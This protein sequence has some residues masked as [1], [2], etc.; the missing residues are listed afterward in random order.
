MI[1]KAYMIKTLVAYI[2]SVLTA[3]LLAALFATQSV[4]ASLIGMGISV[5]WMQRL[6]MSLHDMVGM[7]GI[8]LPLVTVG[9]LIALGVAGVL[10]RRNPTKRTV[11]FILAGAVAMIA[12]HMALKWAFDITLVATA[13]SMTGLFF[14]AVAGAVGGYCFT[15][16]K[17]IRVLP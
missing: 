3:Y 4:V 10:S 13:R 6:E 1:Q 9:F 2:G 11:L 16:I 7:T 17:K 5:S 15:R 12:I 8:F 14:Q